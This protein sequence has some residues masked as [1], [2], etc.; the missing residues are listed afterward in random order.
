M[1]RR[2]AGLLGGHRGSVQGENSGWATP[3]GSCL[4]GATA[5]GKW[6]FWPRSASVAGEGKGHKGSARREGNSD[7]GEGA[8]RRGQVRRVL[9]SE[10]QEP[11]GAQV[12]P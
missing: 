7:R 9:D 11:A 10:L 3:Q 6:S 5:S 8:A 4:A 2:P 12:R 1:G